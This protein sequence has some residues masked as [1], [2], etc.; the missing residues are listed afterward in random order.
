M[1]QNILHTLNSIPPSVWSVL[2]QSVVSALVVSP[3]FV[4]IK[5]HYEIDREKIM[6][7]LVI[8]GSFFAASIA[9]LI[10]VP[11]FAPWIILAQGWI[12]LGIAQPVYIYGAKPLFNKLGA[13]FTGKMI[14]ASGIVE[15]RSAAVP[16][17]GLPIITDSN[18]ED[19]SH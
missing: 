16:A 12:T 3:V 1:F 10:T 9:Y 7:G 17:T 2:V 14:E 18:A 11:T 8:I 15:A 6:L 5:K 19:F 13:W 4:A